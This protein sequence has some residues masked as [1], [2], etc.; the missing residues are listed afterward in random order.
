MFDF[1]HIKI[2]LEILTFSNS[3]SMQTFNENRNIE[4]DMESINSTRKKK[5]KKETVSGDRS[6]Y[7]EINLKKKFIDLIMK[8][9][10]MYEKYYT[11]VCLCSICI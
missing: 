2:F 6:F 7:K 1:M 5:A 4:K 3:K 10:S 8:Q 11:L 9:N